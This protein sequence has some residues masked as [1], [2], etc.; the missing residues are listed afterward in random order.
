[1]ICD[2]ATWQI[3]Q[4]KQESEQVRTRS[5]I[6]RQQNAGMLFP[7]YYNASM[8]ECVYVLRLPRF[9]D[10]YQT[11][12]PYSPLSF[13][14]ITSIVTSLQNRKWYN[15][16]DVLVHVLIFRGLKRGTFRL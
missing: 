6:Q 15:F 13:L 11:A 10:S 7:L 8:V 12:T 2:L 9:S 14:L 4:D 16:D 3:L 5:S 1:M